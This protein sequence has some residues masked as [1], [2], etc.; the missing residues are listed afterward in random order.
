MVDQKAPAICHDCG[1]EEGRTHEYGCDMERCPFC[2]HQLISCPCSYLEL[3]YAYDWNAP[4]CGLPAKV[5]EE[6]LSKAEEAKWR[7]KLEATGRIPYIRWPNLCARCG[8]KWP[9][10]FHVSDEEW[11]RYVE[12]GERDKML[13]RPCWDEIVALTDAGQEGSST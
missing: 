9:G 10:M 3:G 8:G 6:G 5:Y 1:V 13:C 7:V 4:T 11:A 2:G 12:P